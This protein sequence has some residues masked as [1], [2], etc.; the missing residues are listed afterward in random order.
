MVMAVSWV[1]LGSIRRMFRE[2]EPFAEIARRIK[3]LARDQMQNRS[4]FC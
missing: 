4:R 2:A 3:K 1:R